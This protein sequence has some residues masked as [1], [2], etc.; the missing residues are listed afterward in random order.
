MVGSKAALV[1]VMSFL[2]L[3]E[4]VAHGQLRGDLGDGV[5]RG[6]RRQRGA[7][8]DA[9]VHLDDDQAPVRR[10]ERELDVAAARLHADL[11]DDVAR[12]VAHALVLAVGERHGRRHGDGVTG[13]HAHRVEV[14]DGADHDEVVG[15]VADD[16][17]LELLPAQQ[18]LLHQHSCT[19]LIW[20]AQWMARSNSSRL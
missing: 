9:R 20:K 10:V 19:G 8:R 1:P 7:A 18:A 3:V 11:A 16:L 6:L 14:L 4:A 17:E 15:R 12:R 5:A 13:V 2:Q